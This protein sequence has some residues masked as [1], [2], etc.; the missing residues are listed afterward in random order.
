M[1]MMRVIELWLWKTEFIT[2]LHGTFISVHFSLFFIILLLI[3]FNPVIL[4]T[5]PLWGWTEF[6]VC[7]LSIEVFGFITSIIIGLQ[8]KVSR[9]NIFIYTGKNWRNKIKTTT[10]F[11]KFVCSPKWRAA[12]LSKRSKGMEIQW[13][14][15]KIWQN[16]IKEKE[17]KKIKAH[18]DA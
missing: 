17:G 12:E 10:S 8:Q 14:R 2:T 3:F 6:S 18:G 9:A 11:W 15:M 5:I 4:P 7:R 1:N 13:K 16:K